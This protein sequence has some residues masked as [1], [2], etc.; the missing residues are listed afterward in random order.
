MRVGTNRDNNFYSINLFLVLLILYSKSFVN[1]ERFDMS[2]NINF[3][4]KISNVYGNEIL[5]EDNEPIRLGSLC[6]NALMGIFED[7][8]ELDGNEKIRR[9]LMAERIVKRSKGATVTYARINL[10]AE[11]VVLL[12]KLSNKMFPSPAIY[13]AVVR[14]LE[15]KTERKISKNGE[16]ATAV[17]EAEE[18]AEE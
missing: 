11:D 6:V 10:D 15:G 4:A 14:L 18:E 2:L 12:K 17:E 9:T 8:K 1:K 13:T 3:E 7:E 5:G 16:V